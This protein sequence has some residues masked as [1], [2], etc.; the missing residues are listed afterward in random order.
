MRRPA[1]RSIETSVATESRGLKPVLALVLGMAMTACLI[2]GG[3]IWT[4]PPLIIDWHIKDVARIDNRIKVSNVKC[5]SL[6]FVFHFCDLAV[7]V[8]IG[9]ETATKTINYVFTGPLD[10][11]YAVHALADPD[12]RDI[13]T[14]DFGL[15]RLWNRTLT[16]VLGM[17]PFLWLFGLTCYAFILLATGQTPSKR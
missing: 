1:P 7:S 8:T 14:T 13:V 2:V 5:Q 12:R 15:Q 10:R 11:Q 3:A 6:V 9:S 16:L 4:A 17:L